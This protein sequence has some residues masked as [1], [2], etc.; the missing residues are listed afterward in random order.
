[1]GLLEDVERH[2]SD[3]ETDSY[4]ATWRELLN[5]YRDGDLKI[6]PD[7]QRLFRWDADQQ[8]QYIE[9][10]ILGIPSPPVFLAQ[11][12]DGK[13]E[14]LD[15]LQRISTLLK[16]FANERSADPPLQLP[17][18]EDLESDVAQNDISKPSTLM[19]GRI[20]TSLE[21]IDSTTV[22]ETLARAIKYSRVTIILIEK[23]S[24][25]RA[26]YEVFRRLNRF[27]S[28]LSDQEI[29]NC[30]GR[31]LG[32]EFPDALRALAK[33]PLIRSV[34]ALSD[35]AR[36]NM[37][38][39]EALLRLLAFTYSPNPLQHQIRE[40]LDEFMEFGSEGKFVLSSEISNRILRMF[41]LIHEAIP[42]D[43][44]AFRMKNQGFSTNLFDVVA[45][46]VFLNLDT[47]TPEKLRERHITLQSGSELK[48]L[49]GAGS[50]TRKKLEGRL[51]LGLKWFRP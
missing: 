48:E 23:G 25:R 22:P 14:V 42:D 43:G 20:L 13:F 46:G 21:G 41:E 49:I 26:R 35:E 33:Q 30:T 16:F 31:L 27:G 44:K 39:E 19:S 4:T 47:L 29:R 2:R 34:L 36:R 3:I 1:M 38:V 10:L 15:G 6:N 51:R 32:T 11:N 12:D 18:P 37:G 9:S 24:K 45:T 40:Y 17:D 7:Y 50:N 5:Q 28:L 8:T